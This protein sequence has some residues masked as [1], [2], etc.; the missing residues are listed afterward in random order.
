MEASNKKTLG[1]SIRRK[2]WILSLRT[3]VRTPFKVAVWRMH[4]QIYALFF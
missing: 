1:A 3:F 2:T 4:R